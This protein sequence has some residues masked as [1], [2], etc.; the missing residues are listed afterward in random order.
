[1]TLVVLSPPPQIMDFWT[2]IW[3]GGTLEHT[4]VT[5]SEMSL[6]CT[7]T[8]V[9]NGNTTPLPPII[10]RERGVECI[11]KVLGRGRDK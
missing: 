6:H 11:L 8:F 4:V 9:T 10:A 3:V 7:N 2:V 5:V 1:M